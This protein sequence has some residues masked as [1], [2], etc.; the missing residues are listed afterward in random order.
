MN[1]GTG[2]KFSENC[3]VR[4]TAHNI[5]GWIDRKYNKRNYAFGSTDA[6]VTTEAPAISVS[7]EYR[8]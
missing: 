6:S 8:F 4:V 5:L 3:K 2:Y 1:L 7:L